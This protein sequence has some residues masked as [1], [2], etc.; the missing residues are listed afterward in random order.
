MRPALGPRRAA[1]PLAAHVIDRGATSPAIGFSQEGIGKADAYGSWEPADVSLAVGP[2]YIGEAVNTAVGWWRIGAGYSASSVR[3]LGAF[4]TTTTADRRNDQMSDPRLLYDASSGRWFFVAFD[5]TRTE[6]DL[7]VSTSNDPTQSWWIYAIPAAGCP[8]QPRIAVSDTMVAL[9]YDLFSTCATRVPPYIGGVVQLFDKAAMMSGG[10]PATN[11]FGPDPRFEAITP[12]PSFD[13]GS[14]IYM[15]ST[16]YRFSQVVLYT[17]TSVSQSSIPLQRSLINLLRSSPPPYQLG[18]S[19]SLDPGDNR[20]QDAFITGGNIWL[21]ANDGCTV[22]GSTTMQGCIRYVE[23]S[24]AGQVL[25]QREEALANGRSGLYPAF[26]PDG[27]GNLFT[28]YGYSSANDYAS[29]AVTID[30]GRASGYSEL[31]TGSGAD[32]SGRWGDYFSAARD[33]SNPSRVWVA[34]EY[35]ENGGW[36]TFI[37]A[38]STTPFSIPNPTPPPAPSPPATTT[39]T[40]TTTTSTT[41]TPSP[42]PSPPVAPSTRLAVGKPCSSAR[43]AYYRAHHFTCM[44]GRLQKL[45]R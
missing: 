37:A 43:E 22:Q 41:T 40:T 14:T 35:G 30:P 3:S 42:S 23:L 15:V 38:L 11:L 39:S 44:H 5:V 6:T 34:G 27:N 26:R 1:A 29:L 19:F 10:A 32:E 17:A 25:D 31:K 8:D 2:A 21:A 36:G 9:T 16:D 12:A 33:P 28:I 4:F 45:K 18:S 13:G 20:V 24:E 7:A